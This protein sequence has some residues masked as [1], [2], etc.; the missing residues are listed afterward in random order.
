MRCQDELQEYAPSSSPSL[1]IPRYILLLPTLHRGGTMDINT[2]VHRTSCSER[3]TAVRNNPSDGVV[4]RRT[5]I[6]RKS[7]RHLR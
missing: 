2:F 5:S 3:C 7:L 6:R 4:L 1:S